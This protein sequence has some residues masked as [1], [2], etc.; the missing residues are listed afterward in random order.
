MFRLSYY[1]SI[2]LSGASLSSSPSKTFF[3]FFLTFFV[4]CRAPVDIFFY[5][6]HVLRR[7]GSAAFVVG[8]FTISYGLGSGISLFIATNICETIIWKAFSPTTINTGRGTEFE[9]AIIALFH[10]MITRP[11]KVRHLATPLLR[12]AVRYGASLCLL[13]LFSMPVDGL[14]GCHFMVIFWC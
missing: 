12:C 10:L 6:V 11:D 4:K 8:V 9:G 14:F 2:V 1:Y 5:S 7:L 13:A 3:D